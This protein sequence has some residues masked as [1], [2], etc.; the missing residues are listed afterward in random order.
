MLKF[1]GK[2]FLFGCII[3][4]LVTGMFYYFYKTGGDD[5]P[6]P[7]F[8][9]SISFNEKIDFIRTKDLSKI[10]YAVLGSSM[11]L[12]NIDSE[13]MVRTLGQNYINLASWGFKISDTENYLKN[14]SDLFPGLKTVIISTTFVDFSAEVRNIEADYALIRNSIIYDLDFVNYILSFELKYMYENSKKNIWN[15]QKRNSYQNLDF[16]KYGGAVLE[17]D[18]DHIDQIRWNK[19]IL[20]FSVSDAELE[21][22]KDIIVF[23]KSRDVYTVVAVPP[24]RPGLTG[25]DTMSRINT[26]IERIKAV[27][28]TNEGIFVNSFKDGDWN[29]SLFVDY[30]H[31]KKAGAE[32]YTEYIMSKM[33]N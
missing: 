24:Q 15:K 1:I 31:L 29:D 32:K 16:D 11:S 18:S 14:M 21:N 10:E 7:P 27:V 33:N 3:S 26:E 5:L 12:N 13:T 25:E 23:L 19:N 22:L 28:E 8:S 30:C 2:I 17:I 4:S 9:N 20:E 6:A